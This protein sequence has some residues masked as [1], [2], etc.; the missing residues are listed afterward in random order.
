MNGCFTDWMLS[1]LEK[2]EKL[3]LFIDQYRTPTLVNDTVTGF[4]KVVDDQQ[5]RGIF[6]LAGPERVSRVEFGRIFVDTFGFSRDLIQEVKQDEIP[7]LVPRPKDSSLSILK[8]QERYHFTP[9]RIR[10]G[11]Q[12]MYKMRRA[13]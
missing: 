3:K 8:F 12:T 1:T 9:K 5:A 6:H 10:E 11:I 2:K 13:E 7:A 4:I